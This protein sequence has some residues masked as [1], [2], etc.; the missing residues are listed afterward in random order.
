MANLPKWGDKSS[1][2]GFAQDSS[3]GTME[4]IKS[5]SGAA[6]VTTAGSPG[7]L[8]TR[9]FTFDATTEVDAA[10]DVI[11]LDTI[12]STARKFQFI[13]HGVPNAWNAVAGAG[14]IASGAY[15]ALNA[16]DDA[17]ADARLA[18]ADVTG[19]ATSS[20]GIVDTIM[21]SS[22]NPFSEVIF[23]AAIDRLD[24]IGIPIGQTP[25]NIVPVRLEVRMIG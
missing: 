18:V 17:T 6:H 19:G 15:I 2:A 10:A 8:E 23:G 20:S 13:W 9:I 1:V 14:P 7:A 16:D 12:P 4:R 11:R 24:V 25:T 3:S 21:V 22:D 5:T